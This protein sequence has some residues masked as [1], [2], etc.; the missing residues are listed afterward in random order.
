MQPEWRQDGW[1]VASVEVLKMTGC[2]KITVEYE[3]F[4]PR[5]GGGRKY[6]FTEV[7]WKEPC[8]GYKPT[9]VTYYTARPDFIFVSWWLR[10]E[11]TTTRV[12]RL[13]VALKR[14]LRVSG[15]S[16]SASAAAAALLE[17]SSP[18]D[19]DSSD[20]DSSSSAPGHPAKRLRGQD[21][22]DAL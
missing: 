1:V 15:S 13:G 22:D 20:D 8:H 12:G 18:D 19:G 5:D 7:Y 2:Y 4:W 17:G 3:R 16:A 6:S 10:P 14:A 11:A 9:A 21:A